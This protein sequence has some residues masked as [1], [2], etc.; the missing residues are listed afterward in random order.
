VLRRPSEAFEIDS[1]LRSITEG[2]NNEILNGLRSLSNENA[3]IIVQYIS[4]MIT[5]TNPSDNYRKDNIRFLYLFSR[6]NKNKPFRSMIRDNVI[7][8]LNSRRKPESSDPLHKWI[9]TYNLYRIY[10]IRFFKWLYSPNKEQSK[11]PKPK[12]VNNVPALRRKEK[13]IYKPSDLWTE[14]DDLIFLKYCPSKRDKC[15]HAMSW[16]T[17]CRPHELLKLRIKD[18][19]FKIFEKKQYAEV[20]VNGKTGT[21]HIPLIDSIPY[22]KDYLNNE[23]PQEGNPNAILLCAYG[24]SI[25]KALKS[26]SLNYIY[27]NYKNNF[28]PKL[29]DGPKVPQRDKEKIK[30][31]LK[32]PWNPYIRR[33]SALTHKSKILKEHTLRQYAGWTSNS[34]VPQRYINYFGDEASESLLQAYGIITRDQGDLDILKPKQCPNCNEPNKPDSKFC[35]KCRMV[36]TYD[37]YSETLE[38]QQE[39]ESEM[40]KLKQKYEQDLKLMREEMRETVKNELAQLMNRIKPEIIKEGLLTSWITN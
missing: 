31:L 15:F 29:L 21:R 33:H 39:K 7:S 19:T 32:K 6:Y 25:N 13:S 2:L 23:H 22:L 35:A 3:A 27:K 37:A 34:N 16:D 4:A 12:V 20:F 38:K 5:E 18:I 36:L 24:K 40:Q 28:F 30:E 8:F 14:E 11:R 9:G 26:Q 1:R 17:G 10:L